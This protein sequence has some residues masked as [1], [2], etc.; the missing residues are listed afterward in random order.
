M[1]VLAGL[2]PQMLMG[3]VGI[4][5]VSPFLCKLYISE[6]WDLVIAEK[7]TRR[8]A[9]WYLVERNIYFWI[10]IFCSLLLVK[11]PNKKV[12]W[13]YWV[14]LGGVVKAAMGVSV[15]LVGPKANLS[16]NSS[17]AET[18][19][20][21]LQFCFN[22]LKVKHRLL[23]KYIRLLKKGDIVEEIKLKFCLHFCIE[24]IKFSYYEKTHILRLIQDLKI[25]GGK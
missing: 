22:I 19:F 21:S 8:V 14:F 10:S 4:V 7:F 23:L 5:L 17:F 2:N 25:Q 6:W 13:I 12:N 16:W 24:Q 3:V 9:L 18:T 20:T 11:R 15:Y 1:K